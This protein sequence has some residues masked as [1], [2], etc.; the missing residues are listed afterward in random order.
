MFVRR[1][2]R[3][4]VSLLRYCRDGGEGFCVFSPLFAPFETGTKARWMG[5]FLRWQVSKVLAWRGMS[6]PLVWVV[7]PTAERVLGAFTGAPV[8]YQLSDCY[9]AL[10]GCASGRVESLQDALARRAELVVCASEKLRKLAQLRYGK[11][12]YVDHGVDFELF[13]RAREKEVPEELRE[14][15]RPLIGFF[16]NID[17]N[18]VDL[19]LLDRV[20]R[21]RPRM[22]FAL[23]GPMAAEFQPLAGYANVVAVG[24]RPYSEIAR[25]GAAFDLCLMPWLQNEWIAHCNPIKL[26]EYLALGKPI[27]T[28]PFEEL[29]RYSGLYYEAG[30]AE[31][32]AS[33]IDRALA[34]DSA[35]KQCDRQAV[36]ANHSWDAKF[37][38]VLGL[39]AQRGIHGDGDVATTRRESHRE[40]AV[41][42]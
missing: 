25:Y 1:I 7:C 11:G 23:V 41:A 5:D 37:E 16:G 13:A 27:V 24:R 40:V 21:M 20:I 32:F 28:T 39:L 17:G 22:T 36:A 3:K 9:A 12:E 14:C 35:V 10:E 19:K 8:V 4:A 6:R 38:H 33:A 42:R 26:K 29:R 18:T 30:D 2:A 31:S 15:R 34:E